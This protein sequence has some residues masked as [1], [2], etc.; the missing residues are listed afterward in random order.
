MLQSADW[1]IR[2]RLLS[3]SSRPV[4]TVGSMDWVIRSVLPLTR[5]SPYRVGGSS[6]LYL[7]GAGIRPADLRGVGLDLA[8]LAR[9]AEECRL[10]EAGV[11]TGVLCWEDGV[12]EVRPSIIEL[13][14]EEDIESVRD[15]G[16]EFCLGVEAESLV[17]SEE[18][19]RGRVWD[20]RGWRRDDWCSW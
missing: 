6:I 13:D 1:D 8:L 10:T 11:L 4:K 17:R 3:L 7:A 2:A 20:W 14:M 16:P 9:L 12:E 5:S 19:D 15:C 18:L